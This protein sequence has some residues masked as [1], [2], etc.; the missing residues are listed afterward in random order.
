MDT[1]QNS[2]FVVTPKSVELLSKRLKTKIV[3]SSTLETLTERN[4]KFLLMQSKQSSKSARGVGCVKQ[5][6]GRLINNSTKKFSIN[7]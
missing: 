3:D 5:F 6:Y 1:W 4:I 2:L 7:E